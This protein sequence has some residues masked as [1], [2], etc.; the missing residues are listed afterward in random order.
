MRLSIIFRVPR[1]IPRQEQRGLPP[2]TPKR[3]KEA[4]VAKP[5]RRSGPRE[6]QGKDVFFRLGREGILPKRHIAPT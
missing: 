6:R 1:K 3:R 5:K 2:R 4:V